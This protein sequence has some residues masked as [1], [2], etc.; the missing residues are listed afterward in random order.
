[1]YIPNYSQIGSQTVFDITNIQT[2]EL[3]IFSLGMPTAKCK[4]WFFVNPVGRKEPRILSAN[5]YV[6]LCPSQISATYSLVFAWKSHNTNFHIK[7]S[8]NARIEWYCEL[9]N[10][11]LYSVPIV[12]LCTY[13]NLERFTKKIGCL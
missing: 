7:F 2:Q 8:S 13:L 11:N 3:K 4:F 1:M 10:Y 9:S 5:W 6:K 12:A